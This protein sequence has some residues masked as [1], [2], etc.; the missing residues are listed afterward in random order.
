MIMS[1]IKVSHWYLRSSS[2][3]AFKISQFLAFAEFAG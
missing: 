1:F 3:F 2:R